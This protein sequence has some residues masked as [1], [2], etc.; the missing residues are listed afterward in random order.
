MLSTERQ[1][2]DLLLREI[3]NRRAGVPNIQTARFTGIHDQGVVLRLR[4]LFVGEPVH[5]T[6]CCMTDRF[7]TSAMSCTRKNLLAAT[8]KLCGDRRSRDRTRSPPA[9]RDSDGRRVLAEHAGQRS[10]GG[11]ANGLSASGDT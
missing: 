7:C 4:A 6:L 11:S 9:T 1:E 2:L 8:S 5:A 10:C 3:E